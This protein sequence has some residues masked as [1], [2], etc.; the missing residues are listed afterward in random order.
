M[1]EQQNKKYWRRW[2]AVVRAN[3]WC[4]IQ[5]RL[6]PAALGNPQSAILNPQS[7][8]PSPHHV[9]VFAAASHRAVQEARGVTA[10]D[11]RH[12]C[13]I[14]AIGRDKSHVDLTNKEFDALLNYWG[15][16]RTIRGL[17]LDPLNLAAEINRANPALKV[18]D[19]H[20]HF[21]QHD[22]IGGYVV[23]ECERIFGTK[24]WEALSDADL[25]RLHDHL[26]DRPNALKPSVAVVC[27]RPARRSQS[28]ATPDPELEPF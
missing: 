1:T 23:S 20:L 25:E 17:L 8:A 14:V 2:N 27:D 12:G 16:E 15:D 26:R 11:L 21:L 10:E 28:A 22:C 24:N 5:H 19:R 6:D 9:A 7:S 3:H 4:M 13:H 18:R